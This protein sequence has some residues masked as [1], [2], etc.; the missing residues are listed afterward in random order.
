MKRSDKINTE[1]IHNKKKNNDIK[2]EVSDDIRKETLA[3]ITSVRTNIYQKIYRVINALAEDWRKFDF[4]SSEKKVNTFLS[5]LEREIKNV[6]SEKFNFEKYKK[7]IG[8]ILGMDADKFKEEIVK[9]MYI[10]KLQ[11]IIF[12]LKENETGS[13]IKEFKETKQDIMR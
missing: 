2:H 3:I 9:N 11:N 13:D 8:V 5:S 10:A 6:K 1:K 7:I 4:L 12:L